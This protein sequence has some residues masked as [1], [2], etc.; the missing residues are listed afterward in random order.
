MLKNITLIGAIIFCVV[1]TGCGTNVVDNQNNNI[2]NNSD[3]KFVLTTEPQDAVFYVGTGMDGG[4]GSMP[5]LQGPHDYTLSYNDLPVFFS[6]SFA[7]A[8]RNK[9]PNCYVGQP[10]IKIF[11]RIQLQKESGINHSIPPDENGNQPS[12]SYYTASVLKL[13]DIQ[14]RAEVCKE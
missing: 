9:L 4:M 10:E 6:E 13:N 12:E 2:A 11:A 3:Q 7:D 14:V 1:L 5:V 8:V